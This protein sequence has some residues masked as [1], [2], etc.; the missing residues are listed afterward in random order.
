[1]LHTLNVPAHLM[2]TTDAH[3]GLLESV[4]IEWRPEV[5]KGPTLQETLLSSRQAQLIPIRN[6]NDII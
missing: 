2:P 1:M 6:L 4:S 3:G 5:S